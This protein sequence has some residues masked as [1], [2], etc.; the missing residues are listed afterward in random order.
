VAE[1]V[2][3]QPYDLVALLLCRW[4]DLLP[5]DL[6]PD[7]LHMAAVLDQIGHLKYPEDVRHRGHDRGGEGQV[8]GPELQFLEKLAVSP[9]LAGPKDHHLGLVPQL[10]VG[11]LGE[12][13]RAHREERAR[14]P[15][16]AEL[17]LLCRQCPACPKK[18]AKARCRRQPRN[19]DPGF[20]VTP[21]F[22]CYVYTG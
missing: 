4:G 6:V 22:L 15:H 11:P 10:G 9:E 20:H 13:L 12:L 18:K 21:P 2:L 7:F 3:P 5:K 8:H 19:P 16:M 17:D 1:P 14:G